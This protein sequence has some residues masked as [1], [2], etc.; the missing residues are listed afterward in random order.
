MR[1]TWLTIPS[2][3]SLNSS[4]RC[5]TWPNRS[6]I[7]SAGLPVQVRALRGLWRL[8]RLGAVPA[9][10][11]VADRAGPVARPPAGL[12]TV[13]F[14]FGVAGFR[15]GLAGFFLRLVGGVL[16]PFG[17]M[18]GPVGP[19]LRLLGRGPGLGGPQLRLLLLLLVGPATG[20][21]GGFGGHIGGVVR[22]HGRL[23]RL[24]GPLP[25]PFGPLLSLLGQFPRPVQALLRAQPALA[26]AGA[27]RAGAV[28]RGAVRR[29]A[30]RVGN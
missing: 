22:H 17:L 19:A 13:I 11:V 24:L 8:R 21:G 3:R 1:S 5:R 10:P 25:G 9:A 30:V 18:F 7:R 4:N 20:E 12:P 6:A 2:A 15:F 14:P 16:G 27:V 23:V 28:R 26:R 29:C